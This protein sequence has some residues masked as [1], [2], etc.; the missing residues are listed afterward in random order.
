MPSVESTRFSRSAW[1]WT[2]TLGVSVISTPWAGSGSGPRPRR[3]ATARRVEA[4]VG[5]AGSAGGV[6]GRAVAPPEDAGRSAALRAVA[7]PEDAGR[8]AAL[9]AVAPPE[10]AGRGDAGFRGSD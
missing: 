6:V 3:L 5:V 8:S 4:T 9:R 1:L 2:M 7:P 10:G